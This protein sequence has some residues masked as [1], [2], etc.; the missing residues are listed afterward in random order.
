MQAC[1]GAGGKGQC[2]KSTLAVLSRSPHS[3]SSVVGRMAQWGGGSAHG[4]V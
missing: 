1:V 2:S 4:G 3:Q